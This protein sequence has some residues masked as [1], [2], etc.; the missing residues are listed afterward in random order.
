M[1]FV[2]DH[3]SF[4][5]YQVAVRAFKQCQKLRLATFLRDQLL[6][7]SS[8]V[9]LNLAEG[10]GK[11]SP[12]DCRPFYSIALGSVREVQAI[13]DLSSPLPA[14]L[15]Q[16]ADHLGAFVYRLSRSECS[17]EVRFS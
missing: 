5:S 10:S 15:R 8:S 3:A 14:S 7:A 9:V 12:Q 16:D 6:R 13:L 17:A 2:M 4:R 1:D 11:D